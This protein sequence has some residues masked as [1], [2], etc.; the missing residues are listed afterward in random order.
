MVRSLQ[1]PHS[2]VPQ[3]LSPGGSTEPDHPG[4][5]ELKSAL[6]TLDKLQFETAQ[7]GQQA[8]ALLGAADHCQLLYESL[9]GW[10]CLS[11]NSGT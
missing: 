10:G 11:S 8:S 2:L 7:V 4:A 1:Q 6:S 3:P 5:L 9:S